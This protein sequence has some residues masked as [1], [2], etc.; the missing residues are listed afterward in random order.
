VCERERER[1][2]ERKRE[3]ESKRERGY[4]SVRVEMCVRVTICSA[5]HRVLDGVNCG[6][7]VSVQGEY[8]TMSYNK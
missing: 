1:E 2:R 8:W 5:P 4:V 7:M 3:R 6:K